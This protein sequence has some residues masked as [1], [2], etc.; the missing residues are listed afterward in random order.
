MLSRM[1]KL[2]ATVESL[3]Q[4]ATAIAFTPTPSN[5]PEPQTKI[6]DAT[7]LRNLLNNTIKDELIAILGAKSSVMN[8]SYGPGGAQGF[9]D[10]YIEVSCVSKNNAVC[11]SPR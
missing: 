10:L 9:T 4:T 3:S 11:P 2:A 8:V 6:P 7:E 1:T 5:T